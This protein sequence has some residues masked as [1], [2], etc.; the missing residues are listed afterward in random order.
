MSEKWPPDQ[1]T[2]MHDL[3]T[4]LPTAMMYGLVHLATGPAFARLNLCAIIP[5]TIN[6]PAH[7]R[8]PPAPLPEQVSIS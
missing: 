8:P 5:I 3:H 4:I 2:Y 1:D 6:Q 7:V